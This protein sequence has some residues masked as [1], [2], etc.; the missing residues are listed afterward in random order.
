VTVFVDVGVRVGTITVPE[1][2]VGVG[3]D[4][5]VAVGVGDGRVGDGVIRGLFVG[6]GSRSPVGVGEELGAEVT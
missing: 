5:T 3:V 1:G 2:V 6:E 4:G